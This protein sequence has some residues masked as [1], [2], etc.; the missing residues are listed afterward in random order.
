MAYGK[1]NWVSILLTIWLGLRCALKGEDEVIPAEMVYGQVLRLP[2][3]FL[4]EEEVTILPSTL[5]TRLKEKY[6]VISPVL[7]I[8]NTKMKPFISVNLK[9]SSHVFIRHN[10]VRKAL[11][12]P[13]DDPFKVIERLVKFYKVD[14]NGNERNIS[15][16]RLKP[17]F[18]PYENL[19][20]HDHSYSAKITARKKIVKSVDFEM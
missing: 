19:T 4:T 9:S 14:V 8:H 3:D 18:M 16:D 2:G 17:E 5:V 10:S 1:A 13:Y 15:I 6:N 12:M 11:Q 20:Q 7:A